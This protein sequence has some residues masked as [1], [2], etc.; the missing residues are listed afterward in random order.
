MSEPQPRRRLLQLAPAP[1]PPPS[2]PARL[3]ALRAQLKTYEEPEARARFEAPAGSILYKST[4][5]L[6]P[7]CLAHVPAL[8]FEHSGRVWMHKRC[9]AHGLSRAV[10]END[11]SYYLLSNRDQWGR[12]YAELREHVIPD[13]KGLGGMD[14]CGDDPSCCAPSETTDQSATKSCTVLL[15]VTDACNLACPV[16]Y[17]DAKGDR[18]VPLETFR[19]HVQKL[20]EKKGVVDSVQLTGGEA[21]LHPDF[22]ELLE[23]VYREPKIQRVYLPTNGLYFSKPEH[24]ARLE[25]YRDKV[26]VLLQFDGLSDR[27]DKMVRGARLHDVRA[28]ALEELDKRD[29]ALQLTMTLSREVNLHEL[30]RVASLALRTRNVRL[31]ALQPAT[32]SGRY[33]LEPDPLERLTLSDVAKTLLEQA[34]LRMREGD[35]VPIPCSHPGCGWLSVFYRRF[36]VHENVMKYVDMSRVLDGVASKTVLDQREL[37]TTLGT[38]ARNAVGEVL[39]RALR[40]MVRPRDLF[41]VAIK[42]FM[43]R[44]NYDQDRVSHCCH[45]TLDT[46]GNLV[47]FCEYNALTRQK[48]PWSELPKMPS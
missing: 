42:P 11:P 7:T 33:E 45:H 38:G 10:V 1:A 32:Y 41:S 15:E 21:T 43:D 6:C 12:R 31:L 44:F 34:Q 30:G 39:G 8:V 26:M 9:A 27:T 47:S 36:G 35:L 23:T 14:C 18:I 40:S 25:P 2:L 17:S 29:I 16:C 28:R 5:S 19:A 37:R 46:K 4:I 13:F 3:E 48:D 24:A 20:V 22:W